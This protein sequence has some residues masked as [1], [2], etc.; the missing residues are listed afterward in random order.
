MRK[1]V[2]RQAAAEGIATRPE[3]AAL[4]I[5]RYDEQQAASAPQEEKMM[6]EPWSVGDAEYEEDPELQ[7]VKG[8]E[9]HVA[10]MLARKL[11]ADADADAGTCVPW[12]VSWRCANVGMVRQGHLRGSS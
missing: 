8:N 7:K 1:E 5:F 2:E 10:Q 3:E 11:E 4:D 6:R 9:R 12:G